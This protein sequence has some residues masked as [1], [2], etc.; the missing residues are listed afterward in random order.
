MPRWVCFSHDSWC[1]ATR[2]WNHMSLS[3]ASLLLFYFFDVSVFPL[4]VFLYETFLWMTNF[5]NWSL[6]FLILL[7]CCQCLYHFALASKRKFYQHPNSVRCVFNFCNYRLNFLEDFFFLFVIEHDFV[8]FPILVL[9]LQCSSIL[10]RLLRMLF[11]FKKNTDF[12][13]FFIF[14]LL[15]GFLLCS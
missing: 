11:F 6:H 7:S 9:R 14:L 15:Q 3:S 13:A 1:W 10:L 4:Q 12:L 5:G 2:I 8:P